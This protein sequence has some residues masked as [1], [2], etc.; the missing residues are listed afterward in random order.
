MADVDLISLVEKLA[1]TRLLCV[2]DV[3]LDHY[4]YG[5]AERLS[6]EAPIPVLRVERET[7][8]LGG[9]G[10]VLRNL[11]G[12]GLKPCFVSVVGNDSA[13][14][15]V[16]RLAAESPESEVHLLVE[17]G[18][19]TTIKT[20]YI[21][22]T[23]QLLRADREQVAALSPSVREDLLGLIEHAAASCDVTILSDY[24]KGVLEDGVAAAAIAAARGAGHV[25]VVDPKGLDYSVYRGASLLK[26][27]RAELGAATALPVGSEAEVTAAARALI[28]EFELGGVLVSLSQEGMLLVESSGAVHKLAAEA[29]E[30][31]DVSG[32]GDT[33]VAVL[34]AALGAGATPLDA[35]RLAN[36]AAGIVVG[37]VGTAVVHP[38]E[39][40]EAIVARDAVAGQ[41]L[42]PLPVAL[43]HIARWRR[44]GFKVGFTN[45][46]FDLLHPGHVSLLAQARSC[47]DR[48]V[49]GLN[50]DASVARL[51][52]PSRPVQNEAARGAVLSSLASVDMVLV[53]EQDTPVE[54]IKAIKPEVLVKGADYR[55]DEVVGAD[56]VQ[57]Y[58]G[59]VVLAEIVPGYSTTSTIARLAR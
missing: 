34:G 11:Q 57:A 38:S 27:N 43:D 17:R 24:A 36:I 15:E 1:S 40:E 32:A 31:F 19:A 23:Q 54:L 21:A 52:G 10:N 30:V 3:M 53:F 13:G 56:I 6:P 14:R 4:V 37:K 33:V 49:V 18:R 35:A 47:C 20:R 39:L 58:G 12:L 9:A 46:C 55:L 41:K 44:K 26:P 8:T 5:T 7:R 42:L 48:L 45:G 50:S 29:R 51:K 22:G 28:D 59:Q 2:G 25:V 16:S